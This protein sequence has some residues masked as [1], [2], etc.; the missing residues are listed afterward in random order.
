MNNVN[1]VIR[2]IE[3]VNG[4]KRFEKKPHSLYNI[5]YLIII[6]RM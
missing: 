5:Q 2:N 6:Y 3:G 4:Y 1:F